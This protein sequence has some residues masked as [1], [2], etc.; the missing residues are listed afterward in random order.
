M[1]VAT[2]HMHLPLTS[3]E[4]KKILITHR[5]YLLF[6]LVL[7]FKRLFFMNESEKELR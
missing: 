1:L 3:L 4:K 7:C 5:D 2:L 6:E